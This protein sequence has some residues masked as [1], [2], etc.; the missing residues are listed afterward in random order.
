M[1]SVTLLSRRIITVGSLLSILLIAVGCGPAE[2]EGDGDCSILTADDVNGGV[3]LP[4]DSCYIVENDLRVEEGILTVES[5]VEFNFNQ[6]VG[7]NIDGDGRLHANASGGD[8][9]VFQ[10]MENS[11]GT[12]DFWKGIQFQDSFSNSNVLNNVDIIDG[13][14]TAWRSVAEP[15]AIFLVDTSY[16]E[17]TD[18]T[19][20]NTQKTGISVANAS[21]LAGCSGLVFVGIDEE[22]QIT[23]NSSNRDNICGG[24]WFGDE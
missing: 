16:L 15:S 9:I 8:R 13:G 3:T 14:S 1:R 5:G 6:N 4:A 19:I 23:T 24:D 18:T 2:E 10:G 7:L 21:Q 11:T 12:R 17:V 22:D 20:E